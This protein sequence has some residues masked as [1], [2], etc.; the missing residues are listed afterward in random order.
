MRCLLLVVLCLLIVASLLLI[1][2]IRNMSRANAEGNQLCRSQR[3][4]GVGDMREDRDIG[5]L[6]ER[7]VPLVVNNLLVAPHNLQVLLHEIQALIHASTHHK[8]T[9]EHLQKAA[10]S[11]GGRRGTSATGSV[12]RSSSRR[13]RTSTRSPQILR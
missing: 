12:R 4:V 8:D 7:L 13:R 3:G 6:L 9:S 10:A 5:E 1:V 2:V 11:A